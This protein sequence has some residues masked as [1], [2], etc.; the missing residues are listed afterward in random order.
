[1][2]GMVTAKRVEGARTDCPP[3]HPLEHPSTPTHNRTSLGPDATAGASHGAECTPPR[4]HAHN[5]APP[6]PRPQTKPQTA[7]QSRR[8]SAQATGPRTTTRMYRT[9]GTTRT[10]AP[11]AT[12]SQHAVHLHPQLYWRPPSSA[13][14]MCCASA[15]AHGSSP[16]GQYSGRSVLCHAPTRRRLLHCSRTGWLRRARVRTRQLRLM[17]AGAQPHSLTTHPP[18]R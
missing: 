8:R 5:F 2:R 3:A 10:H 12:K 4:G 9:A 11:V 1:M 7:S 14:I 17:R 16:A 13:S 15:G 6:T 18:A